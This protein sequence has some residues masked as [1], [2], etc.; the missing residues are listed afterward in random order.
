ML[1]VFVA[2][3]FLAFLII[4]T[5]GFKD[6]IVES[7]VNS[8]DDS[9]SSL[10]EPNHDGNG[11]GAAVEQPETEEKKDR[12]APQPSS[13]I[14]KKYQFD[15]SFC[16]SEE[17]EYESA[18]EQS[19]DTTP[20][21]STE[22]RFQEWRLDVQDTKVLENKVDDIADIFGCMNIKSAVKLSD[23]RP[24]PA[25]TPSEA[26]LEDPRETTPTPLEQQSL[27]IN[28]PKSLYLVLMTKLTTTNQQPKK[29]RRHQRH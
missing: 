25:S 22:S 28:H 5:H 11:N 19:F 15:D 13:S 29:Y 2:A 12:A 9:F 27:E 3:I 21:A 8:P 16:E 23:S 18:N 17:S 14:K 20:T 7:Q 6:E 26:D 10:Q 4:L 24:S 1:Y